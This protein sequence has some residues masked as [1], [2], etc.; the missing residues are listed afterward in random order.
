MTRK[1]ADFEM[2]LG[3][4]TRIEL[5]ISHC[6]AETA[7]KT[8]LR[9]ELALLMRMSAWHRAFVTQDASRKAAYKLVFKET[10]SHH[11]RLSEDGRDPFVAK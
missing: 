11:T 8:K 10:F 9:N 6:S 5:E 3:K 1:I 7:E 2:R 4:G